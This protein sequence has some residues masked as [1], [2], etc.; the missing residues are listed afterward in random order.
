MEQAKIGPNAVIQTVEALK[1]IYGVP[2]ALATLQSIGQSSLVE[3]PPLGMIPETIFVTLVRALA[4][5]LGSDAT[6]RILRRSGERTGDYVLQYRIPR[7][8]QML[9]RSGI[10]PRAARQYL[11]L[12]AISKS[13]WTFVGS[14]VFTWAGGRE[15]GMT[16]TNRIPIPSFPAE[17]CSFY[18]GTFERLL[19]VLVDPR[20]TVQQIHCATETPIRCAYRIRYSDTCCSPCSP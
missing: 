3:H 10:L 14:G 5:H 15:P 6:M 12:A 18:E 17:M 16:I 4:D 20:A 11:L 7:F 2:R 1:E 9:L 19:R 8:F 13:A